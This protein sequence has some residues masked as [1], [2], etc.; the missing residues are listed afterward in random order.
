MKKR[1]VRAWVGL[2]L[3]GLLGACAVDIENRHAR[4][5]VARETRPAGSVYVGWRVFQDKCASCHGPA[6]G[7]M[8]NAPDLLPRVREMGPRRFVGLVLE[9]YDWTLPPGQARDTAA[10]QAQVEVIMA[11]KDAP[12]SMPA[13]QG[14][15]RV[16]AHIMDL[17]AYL[18]ARAEGTQGPG[19]PA[20]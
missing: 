15:P 1:L 4:Q 5:E 8:G 2:T 10:R 3:T 17:Y 9:R 6:A 18:A 12:L 20:H 7:G 14:E 11:R 16:Q 13:W 19:R